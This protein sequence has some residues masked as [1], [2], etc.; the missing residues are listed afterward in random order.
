MTSTDDVTYTSRYVHVGRL[1]GKSELFIKQHNGGFTN[2]GF[3]AA[4]GKQLV[5][6]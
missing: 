3:A 1:A 4:Y 6:W 5:T 2:K